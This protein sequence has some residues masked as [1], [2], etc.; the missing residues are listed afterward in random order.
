[1]AD[2]SRVDRMRDAAQNR[3]E[4]ASTGNEMAYPS[5]N[6][7]ESYRI[8][9]AGGSQLLLWAGVFDILSFVPGVNS[10]IVFPAQIIFFILF[11]FFYGVPTFGQRTWLWY[12]IAWIIELIPFLSI[13]P[14]YTLMVFRIIAISRS[15]DLIKSKGLNVE[16]E[17]TK[18]IAQRMLQS[19]RVQDF[20]S[21]QQQ[22][23][24]KN[25]DG[26]TNEKKEGAR[27][28]R[29]AGARSNLDA[30]LQRKIGDKNSGVKDRKENDV[31]YMTGGDFDAKRYGLA[32]SLAQ[33]K[34]Q[35]AQPSTPESQDTDLPES[36]ND[37]IQEDAQKAA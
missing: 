17:K 19:K 27:Q 16:G 20:A 30:S 34:A 25:K 29:M 18:A 5:K 21:K 6:K 33:R 15:E 7:R 22:T 10:L 23:P 4:R 26:S 9:D 2:E 8:D 12:A 3:N 36:A 13:F 11:N 28:E 24:I 35:L 32:G 1:M 14:T 37:N 31:D